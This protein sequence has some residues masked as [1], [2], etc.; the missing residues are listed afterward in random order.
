MPGGK[1]LGYPL[2]RK[3]GVTKSWA[4]SFEEEKNSL[5]LA[6]NP[7]QDCP[8]HSLVTMLTILS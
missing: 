5:A 8:V 7:T 4:G 2:N 6:G 3:W 1:N